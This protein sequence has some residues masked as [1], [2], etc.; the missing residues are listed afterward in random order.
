[1]GYASKAPGVTGDPVDT[2]LDRTTL[3]T[4]IE[5]RRVLR[6]DGNDTASFTTGKKGKF[7]S[8]GMVGQI[9]TVQIY[10][11]NPTGTPRLIDLRWRAYHDRADEFRHLCWVPA[12]TKIGWVVFEI[13]KSWNYDRMFVYAETIDSSTGIGFDTQGSS[14]TWAWDSDNEWWYEESTR[15]YIR[16]AMAAQVQEAVPVD[17]QTPITVEVEQGKYLAVVPSVGL[18]NGDLEMGDLTGW[19]YLGCTVVSRTVI[20]DTRNLSVPTEDGYIDKTYA[21]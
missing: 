8:R 6:N 14:D 2:Y 18:F 3:Q 9:E 20:T 7:F 19:L 12:Y 5:A 11:Q 15:F 10:T 1:M 4:R 21:P 13:R 16:V 17:I